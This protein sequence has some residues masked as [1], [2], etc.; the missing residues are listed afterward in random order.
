MGFRISSTDDT[1]NK[2]ERKREIILVNPIL[3]Q[4]ENQCSLSLT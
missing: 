4:C 2:S 1:N 3:Y